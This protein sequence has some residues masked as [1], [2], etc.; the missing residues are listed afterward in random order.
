MTKLTPIPAD[1]RAIYYDA[2]RAGRAE[3]ERLGCGAMDDRIFG[4]FWAAIRSAY[5]PLIAARAAEAERERIARAMYACLTCGQA[6]EFRLI[7]GERYTWSHPQDGHDYRTALC[8][9]DQSDIAAA[10]ARTAGTTEVG[11]G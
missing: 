2:L 9:G 5:A 4:A 10:I 1:E 3:A 6:H 8:N 7:E 11:R